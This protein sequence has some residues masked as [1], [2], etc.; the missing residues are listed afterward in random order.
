MELLSKRD[1]SL[2]GTEE[3]LLNQYKDTRTMQLPSLEG[4]R[5]GN[6]RMTTISPLNPR[7]G[8]IL[9]VPGAPW[10]LDMTKESAIYLA[11]R[12]N[13]PVTTFE[14][15]TA[16]KPAQRRPEA[17][18]TVFDFMR[19]SQ[20]AQSEGSSPQGSPKPIQKCL[21]TFNYAA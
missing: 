14:Q 8:E 21:D 1:T 5:R 2:S 13:R 6:F 11:M 20:S 9:L 10:N 18:R 19:G 12:G 15:P 7:Q 4:K 17:V 3:D 16:G